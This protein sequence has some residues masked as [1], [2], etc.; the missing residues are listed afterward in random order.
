MNSQLTRRNIMKTG[1]KTSVVATLATVFP[2]SLSAE[3]QRELKH[4]LFFTRSAGFEHSV[5]RRNGDELGHAKASHTLDLYAD[6]VPGNV[7]AAMERLGE[8][9]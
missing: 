8:M 7:D 9:I 1:I 4:V 2:L 6:S 3:T 5:I